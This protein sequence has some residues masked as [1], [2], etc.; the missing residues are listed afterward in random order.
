MVGK[1]RIAARYGGVLRLRLRA[2]LCSILYARYSRFKDCLRA[3]LGRVEHAI[4]RQFEISCQK[5]VNLPV[6]LPQCA[7]TPNSSTSD[8]RIAANEPRANRIDGHWY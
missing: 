7:A 1:E 3:T 8:Q 4:D 6:S 2:P 5:I